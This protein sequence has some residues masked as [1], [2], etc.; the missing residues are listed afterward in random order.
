MLLLLTSSP[1]CTFVF[2][3]FISFAL[4]LLLLLLV[5]MLLLS[6]QACRVSFVLVISSEDSARIK[7]LSF[8]IKVVLQRIIR[9]KC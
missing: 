4:F 5:E 6:A 8:G 3:L 9:P 2:S 7:T 1:L